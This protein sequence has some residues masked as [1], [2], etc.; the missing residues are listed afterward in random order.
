[1]QQA[2]A[3]DWVAAGE[4]I[5]LLTPPIPEGFGFDEETPDHIIWS[6]T[7]SVSKP[8]RIV[9]RLSLPTPMSFSPNGAVRVN[10]GVPRPLIA[11]T[12]GG[13]LLFA[14]S[15]SYAIALLDSAGNRMN[16]WSRDIAPVSYTALQ[17]AEIRQ[18]ADSANQRAY[19]VG[20]ATSG[21]SGSRMAIE[22]DLP[23]AAP[24]IA[25]LVAGDS[26]TLVGRDTENPHAPSRWDVLDA[27]GV[28]AGSVE[29]PG[30]FRV[31]AVQRSRVWGV[32][33]DDASRK[34]VA[35]FELVPP[36]A[37]RDPEVSRVNNGIP[38]E[39][40][41]CLP[42]VCRKPGTECERHLAGP[43]RATGGM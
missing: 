40:H 15:D 8:A 22:Y 26:F 35:A 25:D 18:R 4:D 39:P 33:T 29:L 12:P 30:G 10:L 11:G 9:M 5:V 20:G 1:M 38:E 42:E 14:L 16:K 41:A 19:A 7:P 36:Q 2:L 31:L 28:F 17:Q 23:D 6:F 13:P 37:A 32:K 24:M 3:T 21:T 34:T 27:R 43:T